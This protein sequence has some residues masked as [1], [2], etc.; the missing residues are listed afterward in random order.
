MNKLKI[1]LVIAVALFFPVRS[2]SQ[3]NYFVSTHGNDTNPGTQVK[4]FASI[5]RAV[6]KARGQSG[7][8][9]IYLVGGG[10]IA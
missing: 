7:K 6:E 5:A 2:F 3:T 4:P 9:N 10:H 1:F 8:T